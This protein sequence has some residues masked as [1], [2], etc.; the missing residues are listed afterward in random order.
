MNETQLITTSNKVNIARVVALISERDRNIKILKSRAQLADT[1]IEL[2][3][4][5]PE[6]TVERDGL[7]LAKQ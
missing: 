4:Y 1:V 6:Y 2:L 7:L 5:F 3:S